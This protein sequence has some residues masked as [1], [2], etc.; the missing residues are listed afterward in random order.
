[1]YE[2]RI[3]KVR[4]WLKRQRGQGFLVSSPENRR[5]LS[6]YI[7]QDVSLTESAGF[8]LITRGPAFILTDPRYQEEAQSLS[9]FEPV[10]YRQGLAKALARLIPRLGIKILFYEE[11]Y[12]SCGRLKA[13]K[14][15]LPEVE[16]S[17]ISGVV[18]RWRES[19]DP[20]EIEFLEKA[21]D[22]ALEI[23]GVLSREIRPGRTEKEVAWRITELS[24]RLGEGPS[25]PPIV[26][27]GPNA[28]RPHA[29]PTERVLQE[30]EV[31]IVDLGVRYQGYCS[32]LTRTFFL[33]RVPEKL[34]EAHRLVKKAQEAARPFMKA[35]R[36]VREADQQ[37]RALFRSAGVLENYLHSLGHGVGLAVHE[38]PGISFRS[39]RRF[40]SGQVVTLEPGLYFAGLG[41]VREE[42]MIFIL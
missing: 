37:V 36:P 19:K 29:E 18:E 27:S 6:G 24:H 7:P 32:D 21:R 8:L 5:Y 12:L 38:P 31:V 13:L 11:N 16:F 33:G 30:G 35:G 40:R 3:N 23:F 25:F 42:E 9:L 17:G 1:V 15:A 4:R 39:R 2:R 10:I 14:K 22:L 26:A 41:G 28:A 20:Q 34:Q